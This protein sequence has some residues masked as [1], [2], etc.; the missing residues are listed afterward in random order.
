MIVDKG[1]SL[2]LETMLQHSNQSCVVSGKETSLSS[3]R[4]SGP[5]R[6]N[7]TYIAVLL[8]ELWCTSPCRSRIRPTA[9]FFHTLSDI[10]P[11]SQSLPAVRPPNAHLPVP[12]SHLLHNI[13]FDLERSCPRSRRELERR[14]NVDTLF[15]VRKR[16]SPRDAHVPKAQNFQDF[17]G[18]LAPSFI[19]GVPEQENKV[20]HEQTLAWEYRKSDFI[21]PDFLQGNH[22][23]CLW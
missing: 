14:Y 7:N 16:G 3:S 6:F 19:L 1:C 17:L 21:F 15:H 22:H 9:T 4:I 18:R 10:H 8:H 20:R 13:L 5:V 23:A 11:S 12:S 2:L